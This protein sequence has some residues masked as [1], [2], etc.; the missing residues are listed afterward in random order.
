MGTRYIYFSIDRIG[1]QDI[2]HV[3]LAQPNAWRSISTNSARSVEARIVQIHVSSYDG[4]D[5][6]GEGITITAS[7]AWADAPS[8]R[9]CIQC[10]GRV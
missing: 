4:L 8:R 2:A 7:Q 1:Y 9:L 5:M 10:M 6:D 3:I